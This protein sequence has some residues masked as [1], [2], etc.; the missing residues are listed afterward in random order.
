MMT[1]LGNLHFAQIVVVV[2]VG[3]SAIIII[4]INEIQPNAYRF[5]HCHRSKYCR[6][7]CRNK[8]KKLINNLSLSNLWFGSVKVI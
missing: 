4:I 5:V 1:L 3:T 7:P 6:K 2:G 8:K